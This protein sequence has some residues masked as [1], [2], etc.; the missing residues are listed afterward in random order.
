MA[1]HD[2]ILREAIESNNGHINKTTGDGVHAVFVTAIEGINA[3]AA[4][5]LQPTS[6]Y[7]KVRMGLHTGDTEMHE[8]TIKEDAH[9]PKS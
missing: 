1:R 7:L 2:S 6:L 8:V 3:A 5:I 4:A 9:S